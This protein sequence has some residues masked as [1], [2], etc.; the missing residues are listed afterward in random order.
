MSIENLNTKRILLVD[1]QPAFIHLLK[2]LL[3]EIGFDQIYAASDFESAWQSFQDHDPDLCLLD[4]DLGK[5]SR[6]GIDL[7]EKIRVIDPQ[8]PIIFLTANYTDNYYQQCRHV[9]PRSFMNKELSRFKLHHAIDLALLNRTTVHGHNQPPPANTVETPYITDRNLFFKI[10]DF[11]KRIPTDEIA[12]FFSKDK[13]TYARV[14][15][16]NYPTNVQLKTLEDELAPVFH[17]I[18]KTYL[19]NLSFIDQIHPKDSTVAISDETL[20]IGYAYRKSFLERVNL[21]K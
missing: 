1:D 2:I 21:L 9:R 20:P 14:E 6:S 5:N 7:A 10:G 12:F 4:I 15:N 11:Y 16:R 18:H 8:V 3:T 19:V 17:R 13:L